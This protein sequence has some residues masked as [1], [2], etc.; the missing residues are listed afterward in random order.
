[1]TD[2]LLWILLTCAW[3]FGFHNAFQE[4]MIFERVASWLENRFTGF[5]LKPLYSCPLCM[6]SLHG[7]VIYLHACREGYS[8]FGWLMFIV[9]SSG[10]NYVIYNLFPPTDINVKN[11]Y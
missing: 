5:V 11:H 8:V 2:Y 4:G 6:P 3:C 9:C 7:T 10:I 1:M